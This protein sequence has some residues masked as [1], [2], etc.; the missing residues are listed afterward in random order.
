MMLL[1]KL[2][3]PNRHLFPQ[4]SSQQSL[5]D[6]KQIIRPMPQQYLTMTNPKRKTKMSQFQHMLKTSLCRRHLSNIIFFSVVF[7]CCVALMSHLVYAIVDSESS[8]EKT[9]SPYKPDTIITYLLENPISSTIITTL[10]ITVSAYTLNKGKQMNQTLRDI[11]MLK[12]NQEEMKV[13]LKDNADQI[14]KQVGNLDN[15]MD[16]QFGE[17]IKEQRR[18]ENDIYK[19]IYDILLSMKETP[20]TTA[21]GKRRYK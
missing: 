19:R 20:E 13:D 5:K 11:P 8:I 2:P 18:M 16:K 9:S 10:I 4:H 14:K 12:Q 15:K 7:F 6:P 21:T 17:I 3:L 1:R